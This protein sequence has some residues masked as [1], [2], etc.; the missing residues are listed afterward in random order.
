LF[1]DGG[2]LFEMKIEKRESSGGASAGL[3]S[4][5]ESVSKDG[6]PLGN[7]FFYSCSQY[8]EEKRDCLNKV[9]GLGLTRE[10]WNFASGCYFGIG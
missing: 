5:L 8:Q 7:A 9:M 3:C 1:K 10:F 4:N 6:H 2:P